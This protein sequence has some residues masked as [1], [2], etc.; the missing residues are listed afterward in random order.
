[1]FADAI[2][3]APFKDVFWSTSSQPGA[4][5]TPTPQE[6][7]PEREIA[8]ATLSTGP[9]SSGDSIYYA[10]YDNIISC[11]R[12]DGLIFKPDRPLTTINR[13]I[14]DW[15]LFDS[16]SQGELYSTSTTM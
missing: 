1:M 2:G 4:N 16:V 12:A 8:I 13:L 15:A 5:Y 9:V 11:C 10:N 6:A 7:N 3:L 14:A